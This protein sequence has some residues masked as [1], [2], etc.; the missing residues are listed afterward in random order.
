MST[1]TLL[2]TLVLAAT[3]TMAFIVP[4]TQQS[5][6][7]SK[8]SSN[9]KLHE[10]LAIDGLVKKVIKEGTGPALE[11]GQV[12]SVKYS[13]YLPGTETKPFAQ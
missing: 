10:S 6:Y 9:T 2:L 4:T 12:A 11:R 1:S 13:C 8:F 7:T 5:S 3:S